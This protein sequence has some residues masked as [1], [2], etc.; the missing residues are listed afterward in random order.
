MIFWHIRDMKRLYLLL[1]VLVMVL[2]LVVP[3]SAQQDSPPL[4]GEA[5]P[6]A[7]TGADAFRLFFPI[8]SRAPDATYDL[9]L[10]SV[11]ITQATQTA[12]NSVL[13]V[14]GR[15]TV[16]RIYTST[17]NASP[18]NNVYLSVSASN[19]G[20]PLSGSPV[21]IGPVSIPLSSSRD[22]INSSFNLRLPVEWL[23]AGTV[24]LNIS[25]DYTN[26]ILETNEANN[27]Q[28]LA[29]TFRSVPPL[30]I[31][32]VPVEYHDPSSGQTY[33]AASSSFLGPALLK[34][35]P[36]SL[37]NA[38]RR[39]PV[40]VFSQNLR[41]DLGWQALLDRIE[42]LKR[43]DGAPDYRVYYG[44]VPLEDEYGNSWFYSGIGGLGY[45]GYRI[46]IGLTDSTDLGIRGGDIAAHEIGHN[47]G[48]E[49]APC[50]VSSADRQY[51][52]PGGYIGQYGLN[53]NKMLVLLPAVY[54]DIMGYCEQQWV[55]DYT[56]LGFYADQVVHG[57]PAASA[58]PPAPGLLV[59][60]SLAE[61]GVISLGS[62]Y[63]FTGSIDEAPAQ[64]GYTV[65]LLDED[66]AVI[67]THPVTLH[68]A[69]EP[70]VSVQSINTMIPLPSRPFS[71]VR[72]VNKEGSKAEKTLLQ[73][74]PLQ[75]S[76]PIVEQVGDQIVL[77]WGNPEVPAVVRYTTDAGASWTT[78]GLDTLGGELVLDADTLPAGILQF[79][80]LLADSLSAPVT[81][82]LENSK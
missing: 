30:Q 7:H 5:T 63:Q 29:L 72:V 60:A 73:V 24:N 31:T 65:E 6:A 28:S 58:L 78:V 68:R 1:I 49:H 10:N 74:D 46:S 51:P 23:V 35:Y 4:P 76:L 81:F 25:L 2:A 40:L 9:A 8:I 69:E 71:T 75:S 14:A 32:V 27:T 77:H 13:M 45:V 42:T 53:L 26:A 37:V 41:S 50:E 64:S 55:S 39:S 82:T 22:N 33:R 56:Y 80:I 52:Y 3:A 15:P 54:T 12:T 38:T 21:T 36:V 67:A 34:M 43:T 66:G 79:E 16:L 17:N 62:F 11:E 61:D 48:R 59:R 20:I 18:V 70:G 44:L 19:N 47:L 57:G